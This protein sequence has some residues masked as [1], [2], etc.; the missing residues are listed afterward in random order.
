MQTLRSEKRKPVKELD[1]LSG[2]TGSQVA[3]HFMFQRYGLAEEGLTILRAAAA[4]ILF[5]DTLHWHARTWHV[6]SALVHGRAQ[7][8]PYM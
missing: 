5:P 8:H 1:H 2:L 3:E 4:C 6:C 7:L